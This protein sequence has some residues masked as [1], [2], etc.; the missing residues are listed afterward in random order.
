MSTPAVYR[1]LPW[2]RRGL[3]AELRDSAHAASGSL[4]FRASVKL[5]VTLT[6][7]NG[8]ASTATTIAG[9]GDVL[10]ID[11]SAIVRLT[12]RRDASNVEP[13]YLVAV[14]FDEPDFPW[15]L[16]PAAANLLGQLR[17]WLALVV[18]EDRPGVSVGVKAGAPLPQ[19]TIESGA[20]HELPNL[21]DSWA[22]AHTQLLVAEGSGAEAAPALAS[23]PDRHVSRLLCPR[24]L[25]PDARWIACLVPA[26]DAG[27]TRGLGQ[28]PA[29][30]D[31]K[32]AWTD[33]DSITL[34]V[35]FHWTFGTGPQ[36]DFESLARRLQP[37]VVTSENGTPT[38]GTVKM[39]IGAAGGPVDLPAGH[40]QHV[41]QM[42]GALRA[43]Q[44]DDGKLADIPTAFR[45]PLG[46]L[47]DSIADPSGTDPDD[48]AVGP[49]LYGSWP[50]NRFHVAGDTSGWF[51][52]VNLDPR[53]RVAAGLG[54]EVVR[55]EQEN[56][57]TACWQQVG[58][59]LKANALLSRARLSIE[60]ST[61]FHAKTIARLSPERAITFAGPLTDR[62]PMG[63]GTV[64]AAVGPTSLPDAMLDPALRRLVAPT[65]RFVR[66]NAARLRIDPAATG[67]RFVSA[68]AAGTRAVDPT[69]FVPAGVAPPAGRVPTDL[70]DGTVDLGP[71]GLPVIRTKAQV[72]AIVAGIGA[73]NAQVVPPPDKRLAL[74]GD[75]RQTGLV[76]TRHVDAIRSLP[77][78]LSHLDVTVADPVIV[79]RDAA[80]RQ[81]D[82]SGF[83]L[84]RGVN[85]GRITFEAVDVTS[86]G[87]IVLRTP[88]TIP[89]VVIGHL[90]R[91]AAGAGVVDRLRLPVD[92]LRPGQ[93]PV[94]IR[95]GSGRGDVIIDR[96]PGPVIGGPVIGGP[97]IGGP[98]IGGP[99]IGPI[100]E[101]PTVTVPPLVRDSA[102]INRFEVAI[103]Q[104]VEVSAISD[105]APVS[106]LVAFALQTA[107][108]ALTQRCDPAT[109]HTSRVATMVRF[110]ETTL[111]QMRA[112]S[113]VGGLKVAPLFDRIM[114]YPEL[115]DPA[116]RMLARYDRD[117][118]LPGV[119][120]IPPDSVTLLETNPRFVAG[121]L[122]GLNHELN[123]E[124][125]WRR[126]PTDQ[127]GTP[128]RRFW[129]RIGGA[130]DVPPIH[131]WKP[132]TSTLTEVAGG[133]S[134][135]VLL[136]RG[137]L[138][139][140]YPNTVVLAIRATDP[141]TPSALDADIKRPIFSGFLEPDIT[142]F[143][144]DLQ[145]DDIRVGNG[146]FFALQEQVTEPRFGFDQTV[147]G[148]RGTFDQWREAAW[149]D[150]A[151][152]P[153]ATFDADTLRKLSNPP[154]SLKP[155]P[156]N[157]ASVADALFQNPVQ[158]LVHGR[159]LA[160]TEAP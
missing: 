93:P 15:M 129:D 45:D 6:G 154:L 44:Q 84:G 116:Y 18:V 68:L 104:L 111:A 57:M 151:V 100:F 50:A 155:V 40:P 107:A 34:P 135:L 149:P 139:R 117:R 28:V 159:H 130:N 24:Y 160:I 58:A 75:L 47:L 25:R 86:R 13:N 27:V 144:F 148:N 110:G 54:A 63:T 23:D 53:A 152:Q 7:G 85:S 99:V 101:G 41:V 46:T 115:H 97:V 105:A 20:Q 17:P 43:L 29:P 31:L 12:P 95:P 147:D 8:A 77:L 91:G 66:K 19:L 138:L 90:T 64:K 78:D 122:A 39:H 22:W 89:N 88:P 125:L 76:T 69:D 120:A 48:G 60:A 92:T 26:F 56:L 30:A 96:N 108:G 133:E 121:F 98:V 52:E 32:P 106:Q 71:I 94:V 141:S 127:R 146:W 21:V 16:T 134:N 143:G 33:Q 73:A 136:I 158:V 81:P 123:R 156:S 74:R 82:P 49:P 112:G 5:D 42:D 35:Y 59:V 9:P 87:T 14:D 132:L 83:L 126:Y 103:G 38:V 118:L 140:R 150:V 65:N 70:L 11:L 124:L 36:G 55:R 80:A 1:F 153:G 157:G 128:M 61:M 119:D 114:A 62:T 10:G 109:A 3:V 4:P 37:F 137:E 131:Q 51:A 102:V 72:A 67:A 79:L 113:L 145:D 142:F 2:T